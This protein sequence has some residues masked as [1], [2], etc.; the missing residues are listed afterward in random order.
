M[1]LMKVLFVAAI[2]VAIAAPTFAAVQNIKVSGS[3]EEQAIYMSN[4]DL[5]SKSEESTARRFSPVVDPG[6]M[7]GSGNSINEDSE[8]FV[9]QT[10]KVGV[11]SDLTDNVSAS[12]VLS[13]QAKWGDNLIARD[14]VSVNKAFVT[15]KEFFYQP[16]TLKIGRQD[17]K[18]GN[19][20]IVGPGIYRDP[21]GT[22]A[23]PGVDLAPDRFNLGGGNNAYFP[24]GANGLQFSDATYYDAIRATLDLDPWTVDAIYSK[25]SQSGT[26]RVDEELAGANVAYKFDQY[27]AKAEAYYFFK[28][29]PGLND[30]MGLIDPVDYLATGAAFGGFIL[31]QSVPGVGARVYEKEETHVFGMRGDIDPIENLVLSGE[32]ALQW[33]QL[34]DSE[35]PWGKGTDN[36]SINRGKLAWAI[37]AYGNYTWKE[38]AYKPN[39][40]LGV[41]ILSG[42]NAGNSGKWTAWDPMFRGNSLS[43][44]RGYM[45]GQQA[46]F[47]NVGGNIYQTLD[48]KDPSGSTDAITMYID[49]GLKP[50]DD[51]SIKARW[52][53]F[54]TEKKPVDGRSRN[55]GDEVDTTILYDY[56]EDV[57]FDLTGAV[58]VPETFYDNNSDGFTKSTTPAVIVTG[59]VKVTF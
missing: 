25:I 9:L 36:G 31:D 55:L 58:F 1:K 42:Q 35:G 46:A 5:A 10:I 3:I 47:N 50:M 11:D 28:Y 27:N 23:L 54:W 12:I 7:T 13:N 22:F 40:G 39:L 43:M 6:Q 59:G 52:L 44:I 57:Q 21:Q 37:N 30:D 38:V 29:N 2:V 34:K 16:L 4:F 48:M 19:G 33:G 26:A 15:L 51:L 41:E 14:A 24:G 17:L 56:T 53:H 8:S 32:G 49:G 20:F 18:F 45:A